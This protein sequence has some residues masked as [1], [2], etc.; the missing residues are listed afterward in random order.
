MALESS[1][2]LVP[3]MNV[4]GPPARRAAGAAVEHERARAHEEIQ[5]VDQQLQGGKMCGRG[6]CGIEVCR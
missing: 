4:A 3:S 6:E 5:G 1:H 2:V